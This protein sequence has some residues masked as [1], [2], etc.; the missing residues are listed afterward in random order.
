MNLKK[1][2][3]WYFSS[4]LI[5]IAVA[6][7]I[8]TV[9]SSFFEDTGNY[10]SI[11][12]ETFLYDY[13]FN[14]L[15]LLIGVLFLTFLIGVGCAYLVSFYNFPGVNFFKWALILSFAVP[16]YIYAYSLTAFFENYGTAF[17]ILK[18][19]FGE[20]NYNS[21]I[22]KFDG[23]MGAIISISFS[24][25][26][27]VY[28]LTRASFHYQSQNLI[29][30]GKNLGFSKKKSFFKIILP[31]AR[32]AIVAGLS[33]VA[34]ETLSDFGSVSFFGISTLTTGIYN[35]WISFDDL[36]LAN[37]LSFYL[38]IF[39]LGLFILENLSRKKAQYHTPSKG[40]FK[41]K[42]LTI[43]K[44]YKSILALSFCATVFFIS[45]L[46]PVL[47]M[48]YWT[49]IFPKHLADLNLIE[50]FLNTI[51]LV[52]LSSIV[53]ISLAFISNY[54]NRVSRSKF[55]Q[56]LTTF[57]ISGYAI[58]GIILA[59]AFITFVSWFDNN[60]INFFGFNTIKSIFIG[61]VFGLVIVYFVRF[62]SLASNG[63]KSGY[64][65][66]NYS[67]DES[68]YLL[69][70]SKFKTF[71]NIHIPYLKNSMILIGILIA[72][73]IIKELPITLI[74][75]PFNFE[76]FATTA[77]VFASQD[78]LEAAAAPSLFLIL[79]ASFFILI[80]SRYILKD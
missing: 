59:V 74:M 49:I 40:G 8:V 79:I 19:L 60:I 45:F 68:A 5:S 61:S 38:L 4:F 67:I 6:I 66:I 36:A 42:S 70:Y 39:I 48:F 57:S 21:H 25:F 50:L 52:F 13:I 55:L 72:I 46:F 3:I 10:S 75:R 54:G 32:P 17:S 27:Y 18:N 30:L 56:I 29:E 1:I 14:S 65:K 77:Y 62:Y 43:L 76:T 15:T 69:G 34:M 58:P 80:T 11:L 78:L 44:G 22:P 16:A 53:L 64:L 20:G 28:V 31:S 2:N 23:M 41:S 71:K 26:G 12:K 33:L 9:F 51:M 37:R 7:P 63:I 73:E 35:A 47:Q 24:L